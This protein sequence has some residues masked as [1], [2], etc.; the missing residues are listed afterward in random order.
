MANF[1]YVLPSNDLARA[2]ATVISVSSG[3]EDTEYPAANIANNNPTNPAKVTGTTGA[4]LFDLGSA[5]EL[6]HIF[7]FNHNFDSGLLD[8]AIE[9]NATDSWGAPTLKVDFTIPSIQEDRHV[10]D[11]HLDISGQGSK[12][13]RYWRI[14]VETANSQPVA[15]GGVVLASALTQLSTNFQMPLDQGEQHPIIEHRTPFGQMWNYAFGSKWRTI[16]GEIKA[17]DSTD[18][19]YNALRSLERDALDRSIPFAFVLDPAV[20]DAMFVRM[21][22]TGIANRRRFTQMSEFPFE[23]E[24]LSRGLT[25]IDPS[26]S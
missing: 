11:P 12:T 2:S 14:H 7:I 15:I 1:G 22:R 3:V 10:T 16:F 4:W 26:Q 8:V 25:L 21:R 6:N 9:G 13:F 17:S 5:I 24:E 20:N 18:A 19:D 23:V